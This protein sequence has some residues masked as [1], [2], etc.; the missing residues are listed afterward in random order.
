MSEAAAIRATYS[1]WRPVKG[2][3]VLQ[4]VF[5]VPLEEQESVLK[6]LGAPL[7]DRS[8]W[9]GI[10]RLAETKRQ[11]PAP[12][13]P[14]QMAGI[15][16][17]DATFRTF[18]AERNKWDGVGVAVLDSETAADEVRQVC[19]V[20]S[21]SEIIDGTPAAQKFRDLRAEFDAWRQM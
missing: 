16:C 15:L 19:G 21:R 6:Y 20:K 9:C 8:L 7:P 10:A 11:E 13:S 14:A 2:R 12:K 4:L 1:D 3:K 17:G 5:E 18:L